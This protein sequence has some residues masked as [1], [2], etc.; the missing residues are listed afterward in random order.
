[1]INTVIYG[2]VN[3]YHVVKQLFLLIGRIEEFDRPQGTVFRLG[4]D[5]GFSVDPSV[6]VKM[7]N[8]W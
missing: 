3:I 1:M 4:A 2:L 8:R 7:L 5:W 6:L